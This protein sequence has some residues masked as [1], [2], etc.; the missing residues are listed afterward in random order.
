[1]ERIIEY[2]I[3]RR[4]HNNRTVQVFMQQCPSMEALICR[5]ESRGGERHISD[6][7]L[8]SRRGRCRPGHDS[9]RMAS[10]CEEQRQNRGRPEV[11][12][13]GTPRRVRLLGN[14]ITSRDNWLRNGRKAADMALMASLF[15]PISKE[16]RSEL[17]RTTAR[18]S[19]FPSNLSPFALSFP[20]YFNT[21]ILSTARCRWD[22]TTANSDSE[23][24]ENNATFYR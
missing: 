8:G 17:T 11:K 18:A 19:C 13:V 3:E 15:C 2:F 5:H 24:G 21:E 7:Q 10:D 22:P 14:S 23:V 20:R 16:G 4:Q 6:G 12:I 1:M 9:S